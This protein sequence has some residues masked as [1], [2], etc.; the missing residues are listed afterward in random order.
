MALQHYLHLQGIKR[1]LNENKRCEIMSNV[2]YAI[3]INSLV[4]ILFIFLGI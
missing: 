4:G 2:H 3:N 1:K